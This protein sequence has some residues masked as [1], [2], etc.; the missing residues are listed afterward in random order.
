MRSASAPFEGNEERRADVLT[1]AFQPHDGLPRYELS[2]DASTNVN[3][4]VTRASTAAEAA[5]PACISR[6]PRTAR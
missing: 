4:S 1:T 6:L 2:R 5:I 3:G